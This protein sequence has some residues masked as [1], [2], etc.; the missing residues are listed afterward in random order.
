LQVRF[1]C[2]FRTMLGHNLPL[3]CIFAV[4]G[5]TVKCALIA[6]HVES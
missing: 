1:G 3:S 4:S 5:E 6:E 2:G